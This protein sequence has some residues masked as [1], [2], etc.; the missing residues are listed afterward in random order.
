[1]LH[2]LTAI[3]T[4]ICFATVNLS[5]NPGSAWCGWYGTT[6]I[7]PASGAAD[8]TFATAHGIDE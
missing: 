2:L 8:F 5:T 6:K 3:N 7:S 1:M 4:F